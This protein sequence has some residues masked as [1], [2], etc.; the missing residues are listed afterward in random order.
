MSNLCN[1]TSLIASVNISKTNVLNDCSIKCSLETN[2]IPSTVKV[3]NKGNYLSMDY[4]PNIKDNYHIKFAGVKMN[5]F[6]VRFY[7][8][9][10]HTYDKTYSDGSM[11]IIHNDNGSNCIIS[12]PIKSGTPTTLGEKSINTIFENTIAS[13]P[14]KNESTSLNI[15]NFNLSHFVPLSL[16]YYYYE[17][18]QI[19]S[20]CT[21]M[22]NYI[23]FHKNDYAIT[24]SSELMTQ[25]KKVFE[26]QQGSFSPPRDVKILSY[27]IKGASSHDAL[28]SDDIYIDCKPIEMLGGDENTEENDDTIP[29][30]NVSSRETKKITFEDV[31]KNPAFDVVV[32]FVGLFTLYMGGKYIV[33]YLRS[34]K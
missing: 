24:I 19:F 12:I 27:N 25:L 29:I 9:S 5:V 6:E 13:I 10:L 16:P 31:S 21:Q 33:R 23:V 4:D 14:N 32:G 3:H 11:L 2:Y 18:K 34:R 30:S 22:Y 8:P 1:D 26:K 20:P 15:A 7:F 17:G 28:T